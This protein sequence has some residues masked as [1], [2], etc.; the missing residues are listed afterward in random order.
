ME[1]VKKTIHSSPFIGVFAL[2]TEKYVILPSNIEKKEEYNM[3]G[4]FNAEIIK[5]R[6]ADSSLIGILAVGNNNGIV[7]SSIVEEKEIKELTEKGLRV[8]R[9]AEPLA[10]G[11]LVELNDTKGVC[12]KAVKPKTKQE[13][14]NFL[15]IELKY[16]EIANTEVVGA[17][18]V[19]TN[20]GF[21]VNPHINTPE[22]RELEQ[23]T[24]LP[25]KP[26]TAN[27]G[28]SFVGISVIANSAGAAVG[29]YTTGHEL[30]RIDEGLGGRA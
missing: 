5:T 9:L 15:K 3:S 2:A 21:I 25:G 6:L 12:S 14:E 29:L 10:I 22:F 4:L 19:M 27:L 30:L 8:K 16:V 13:I 23:W 7:V 18:V 1:M 11:N 20:T 24:G 17:S 28:D 26:T